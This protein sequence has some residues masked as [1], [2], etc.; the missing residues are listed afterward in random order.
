MTPSR[1]NELV[2]EYLS[3]LE[4]A[5]HSL[6]I[7]P[8]IELLAQVREHIASARTEAVDQGASSDEVAVR[9]ILDRLGSPEDIAAAASDQPAGTPPARRP[10]R[11]AGQ[12]LY[13]IVTVLLLLFGG[14]VIPVV[15]WLG[16]V[17]LLWASPRWATRDKWLGTAVIP[18]GLGAPVWF[19]LG[20][21]PWIP[22]ESC[23]EVRLDDGTIEGECYPLSPPAWIIVPLLAVLTIAPLVMAVVL[24][25]RAGRAHNGPA[26]AHP[27]AGAVT[28]SPEL[29]T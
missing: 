4:Q 7:Q 8:R 5:A 23:S 25:K 14:V 29:E 9:N 28:K 24:L 10:D 20:L 22:F 16:G 27:H 17:V 11:P 12:Q 21:L 18:L 1:G 13:D 6:P 3:R 15:G 19:K 2:D 26:P